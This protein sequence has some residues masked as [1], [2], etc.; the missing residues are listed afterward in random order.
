MEGEIPYCECIGWT[1][2]WFCKTKICKCNYFIIKTKKNG[3]YI[4]SYICIYCGK[5]NKNCVEE[6]INYYLN[7]NKFI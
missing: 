6:G 5:Y 2:C 4:Q 7:Y 3:K 1:F